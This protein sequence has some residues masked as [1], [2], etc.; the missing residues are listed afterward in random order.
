MWAK[1]REDYLNLSQ[2]MRV[3]FCRSWKNGREEL[4]AEV[5][6]VINGVV[7]ALMRYR[8]RE[9]ESLHAAL[10]QDAVAEQPFSAT[11][12]ALD[13]RAAGVGHARDTMAEV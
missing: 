2:I 11:T 9:A 13:S 5:E 7:Q 3:R 4:T 6:A 8:G 1:L 12:T 10:N